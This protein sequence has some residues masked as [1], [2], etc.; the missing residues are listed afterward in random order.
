MVYLW[1]K[2]PEKGLFCPWQE[3]NPFTFTFTKVED[4]SRFSI[5]PAISLQDGILHCKVV[6]G[7]FCTETFLQFI[8]GLLEFMRPYPEPNSVIV[9]DNCK[10]H[11]HPEI[12]AA[13]ETR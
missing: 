12:Q 4:V 1:H 10:I 13:I 11:K 5:L 7:S 6:E 9:M 3:V 2:G 8:E